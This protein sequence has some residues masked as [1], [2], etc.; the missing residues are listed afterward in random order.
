M[1]NTMKRLFFIYSDSFYSK[2]LEIDEISVIGIEIDQS[3]ET[4]L[5]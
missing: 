2:L 1:N 3:R 5:E 4:Q